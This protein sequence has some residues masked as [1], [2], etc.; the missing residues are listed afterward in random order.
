MTN[1]ALCDIIQMDNISNCDFFVGWCACMELLLPRKPSEVQLLD[2]M[3]ADAVYEVSSDRDAEVFAMASASAIHSFV[4]P[5]KTS[6][7]Y[8]CGHCAFNCA[9]CSCRAGLDREDYLSSPAEAA[10]L[11]FASVKNSSHG[12]FL[13][14]AI[15]RNADYTQELLAECARILRKELGFTGFLHVKVM[16]GADPCLIEKTGR[17]ADRLS[18]N[19]EVAKSSGYERIAKQKNRENILSPMSEISSRIAKNRY[20]RK[21]FAL[22]QT[23]QL[24]AGST[25]EDD[26]T[27]LTL[28]SALYRKYALKRVY[29]SAFRYLSPAK[30]YEADFSPVQTPL[31]RTARLYQADSLMRLYGFSSEEILPEGEPF[32]SREVDPKTAYALRHLDLYPVEINRADF[33]T[34][35]RVPGIGI[36]SAK[37]IL[38]AR[39]YCAVT[40]DMLKKMRISLKKSVYF[41]TCGGKYLDGNVLFSQNLRYVLSD[42]GFQLRL[43]DDD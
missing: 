30:G 13:S 19:I 6:K 4:P 34:L 32:L 28:T 33:E 43:F 23:T 20:E 11:A 12:I 41:I 25:G 3:A 36:V 5:Q 14:S 16:P 18:V 29:F 1:I 39:R 38:V 37:K 40:H 31:W 22:S 24:M 2:K 17:Y 15:C 27:I 9:Y 42:N 8:L 10:R 21:P 7:L 26:R 35:L